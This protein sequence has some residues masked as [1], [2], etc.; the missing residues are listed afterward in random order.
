VQN[1]KKRLTSKLAMS[2]PWITQRV[3]HSNAPLSEEVAGS[4]KKYTDANRFEKAIRHQMAT[5]MTTSELH[6]LRNMFEKLDTEGTGSVAINEL[7]QVLQTDA[8]DDKAK[9]TL[10]ALDLSAF[11]LDG[12]GQIDWQEFVAGAMTEHDLYNDENLDRVFAKLD[13]NSDG[14]LCQRE[15]ASLL[16]DDHAFTRELLQT[17]QQKREDSSDATELHMTLDEFKALMMKSSTLEG[18]VSKKTKTRGRK[19]RSPKEVRA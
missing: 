6:R 5:T 8:A 4:L 1:P 2:H 16:G 11:D 9:T 19:P 13:V 15:V 10:A 17:V 14:T 7:Q 12:N 3:A 18:G